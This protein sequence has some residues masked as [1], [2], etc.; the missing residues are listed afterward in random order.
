MRVN[1]AAFAKALEEARGM[2]D[3]ELRAKTNAGSSSSY[4]VR[5]GERLLPMKA[6]LRLA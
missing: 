2:T 6:V 3:G 5:V 1:Y 4:Y